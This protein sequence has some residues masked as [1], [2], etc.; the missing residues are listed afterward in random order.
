MTKTPRSLVRRLS[1]GF[2]IFFGSLLLLTVL[3][4]TSEAQTSIVTSTANDGATPLGL[5]P[6]AP[7][8]SFALSGLDTVN[9]F[10]GNLNFHLPLVGIKGRGGVGMPVMLKIDTKKWQVQDRHTTDI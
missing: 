5:S 9:L 2:E 6:G 8:G 4:G 7:E 1:Q 10:N 3:S